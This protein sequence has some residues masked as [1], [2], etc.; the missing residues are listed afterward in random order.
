MQTLV[1]TQKMDQFN[2]EVHELH[3]EVTTLRAEVEKLTNLVSLLAVKQDQP[4]VRQKYQP[5]CIQLPR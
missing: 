1:Q 2:Q 4:Q 3:E 5:L